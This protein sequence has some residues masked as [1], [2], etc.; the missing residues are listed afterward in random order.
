[1]AGVH[2]VIV[3]FALK[4]R[5]IKILYE[6]ESVDGAPHAVVVQN[7][8][9]YLVDAP[10]IVLAARRSPICN[11][12]PVRFGSMPN[13]GGH[14][15]LSDE[16]R[17]TLLA[18]EPEAASWMRPFLSADEFI[19]GIPRWCLWLVDCPPNILR[20]MPEVAHRVAMVKEHRERSARATTNA[21]SATP[22]LFGEIRQPDGPYVVIPRHSSERRR[23]IPLG[24]FTQETIVGDSNLCVPDA[25]LRAFGMLSSTMHNAWVRYT[26]GR[27]KSDF[28]YSASI[29]YNNF[30][31]PEPMVDASA[32]RIEAAAE[33]VLDARS[34]FP[35][36]SLA[37]LYDPLAMPPALVKAHQALD[38]A[39][40]AAY[41][42]KRFKNDADRVTFLFE[43]YGQCTSLLATPLA[44]KR[45]K[46]ERVG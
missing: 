41:G 11:V 9:P 20:Q 43:L 21:L 17:T 22:T 25:S 31:W 5:P 37:D 4:D 18:I 13:D 40:D 16:E 8:N 24:R 42:R 44:R 30:P 38:V 23:F 3:G 19:N 35:G 34:R 28:R 39:V 2:C 27:I 6:Y 1:V 15:L 7:I 14:L 36:A 33:S 10:D 32:M 29:V 45:G 12:P 26:C 46:R